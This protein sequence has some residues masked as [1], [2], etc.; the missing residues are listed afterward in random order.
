MSVEE[1]AKP[2]ARRKQM[3][4]QPSLSAF[5]VG[6][7]QRLSR[8]IGLA[9]ANLPLVAL[10][11]AALSFTFYWSEIDLE[12]LTL[13][14]FSV[15]D[16][17]VNYQSIWA[18]TYGFSPDVSGPAYTHAIMYLF[19]LP[20]VV[21]GPG[22]TFLQFL[23]IFQNA[24]LALGTLPIYLLCRKF[25]PGRFTSLVIGLTY[26]L[27]VPLNGPI[28]FPFHFLALFPTL[29]L[30][31]YYFQRRG[32]TKTSL[33]IFM[34]SSLCNI[35]TFAI[36]L[37]YGI[38]ILVEPALSRVLHI[39]KR[40]AGVRESGLP[41]PRILFGLLLI[42]EPIL[43]FTLYILIG[44]YHN[45]ES[46]AFHT[47]NT[48]VS[49]IAT[50]IG[51]AGGLLNNI[52]SK[53]LT[54]AIIFLPLMALPF[55][56]REERWALLPYFLLALAAPNFTGFLFPFNNQYTALFI[57]PLFCATIRGLERLEGSKLSSRAVI[58]GQTKVRHAARRLRRH[59]A[60]AAGAV[61]L[62][63]TV[64]LSLYFAPWGPY[65]H[66]LSEDPLLAPGFYNANAYSIG[67]T[68]VSSDLN[69]LV[70]TIPATGWL[71]VQ[72]N[73]PQAVARQYYIIPGFYNQNVPLQ[74]LISD[75]FGA[76]FYPGTNFGPY[77]TS[78]LYWAN[79]YLAQHWS[80]MGEADGAL[81][82]SSKTAPLSVY[83]P[84]VQSFTN[85]QFGCT[86][87]GTKARMLTNY[88][89]PAA[90]GPELP[91]EDDYSVFSPGTFSLQ[92]LLNV[93]H[94]SANAS[95]NLTV[96]GSDGELSLY[97]L[98]ASAAPWSNYSGPVELQWNVS[99]SQYYLG[100]HFTLALNS[101]TGGFA[102]Q[103]VH[104]TQVFPA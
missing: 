38:G 102:L 12:R 8:T 74:Y 93:D 9:R 97:H 95:L 1:P 33:S 101:W 27:S 56:G 76:S 6:L 37:F 10:I 5:V 49:G 23:L 18:I 88:S 67:N 100:M 29:F 80:V 24:W 65:N 22:T 68:T 86:L 82:L 40:K 73:I 103:A 66:S 2:M 60:L 96:A 14:H 32:M 51:L 52:Q 91:I 92:L 75:P 71:L 16:L 46:F 7:R 61:C 50:S 87:G 63:L 59:P 58:V 94:P 39:R 104:M 31:G 41:T 57:G 45:I 72:N 69:R 64:T 55:L 11:F 98:K 13:F 53:I 85:S 34:L 47:V 21:L 44:G 25:L 19:V 4:R 48:N 36:L 99:F 62:V 43:L 70:S 42:I 89:G 28:V 30:L 81:L 79:F 90:C 17:G 3:P 26:L 20:M 54:I 77:N 78:M 84:L 83:F 35:G 15:Y